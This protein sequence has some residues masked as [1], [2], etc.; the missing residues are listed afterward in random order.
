VGNYKTDITVTIK[1][2][3]GDVVAT[4]NLGAQ[5]AGTH[6]ITWTPQDANGNPLPDGTYSFTI[7]D[8]EGGK[9]GSPTSLTADTVVGLVRDADGSTSLELSNGKNITSSEIAAM[10]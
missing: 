3:A 7:T 9:A 1:N 2:S 4:L 6:P 5:D 10:L 8:S